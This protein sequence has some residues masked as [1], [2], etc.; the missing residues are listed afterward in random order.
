M[1]N[2]G[3]EYQ[4]QSYAQGSYGPPPPQNAYYGQGQAQQYPPPQQGKEYSDS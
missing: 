2:K 3:Y 4:N 1:S